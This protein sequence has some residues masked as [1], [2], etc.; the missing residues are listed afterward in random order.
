MLNNYGI[1]TARQYLKRKPLTNV[2]LIGPI[3]CNYLQLK[4]YCNVVNWKI[5]EKHK[6]QDEETKQFV[7]KWFLD[8][9]AICLYLDPPFEFGIELLDFVLLDGHAA[10]VERRLPVEPAAVGGD[11]RDLQRSLRSGRLAEDDQLD[12]F[13]VEAVDVFSADEVQGG[14]LKEQNWMNQIKCC[15]NVFEWL[16]VKRLNYF[17]HLRKF[18][19]NLFFLIV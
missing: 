5:F 1:T 13:L 8:R 19:A 10:V 14:V 17:D 3:Y 2:I 6:G 11:V 7:L 4:L 16:S 12:P 15:C 18:R 9:N